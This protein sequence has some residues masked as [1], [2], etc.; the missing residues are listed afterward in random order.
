MACPLGSLFIRIPASQPNLKHLFNLLVSVFFFIPV[1][2]LSWGFAQLLGSVLGT[3]YIAANVKGPNMPWIVFAYVYPLNSR[4]GC[5]LDFLQFR[6]GSSHSQVRDM[7][8][9]RL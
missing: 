4:N 3:Y 6:H 5:S 7:S 8:K 1:L 2:D 9:T